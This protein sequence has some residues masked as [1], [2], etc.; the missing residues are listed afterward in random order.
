VDFDILRE[1]FELVNIDNWVLWKYITHKEGKP[2]KAPY[3]PMRPNWG[4]K[5][6][7]PRTW[8][9]FELAYKQ[10]HNPNISMEGIGFEVYPPTNFIK[11]KVWDPTERRKV[12]KIVEL[13][14]AQKAHFTKH[15]TNRDG[16]YLMMVDVDHCVEKG[17]LNAKA[18]HILSTLNSYSEYSPSGT[19]IHIF[20]WADPPEGRRCR[21]DIEIYWKVRF[22]TITGKTVE[23]CNKPIAVNVEGFNQIYAEHVGIYE[24]KYTEVANNFDGSIERT[25]IESDQQL[26]THLYYHPNDEFRERFQRLWSGDFTDYRVPDKFENAGERDH[27]GADMA[28]INILYWW[29]GGDR[30]RTDTLFRSSGL[31]RSK[32]EDRPDYREFTLDSAEEWYLEHN[33]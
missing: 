19:G 4:A 27:S 22:L 3:I 8:S 32:W 23:G 21:G 17:K 12:K 15:N 11:D 7:D 2:T 24:R 5:A 13:T 9:T 6:G 18:E 28:L 20:L 26:K 1:N 30:E 29:T 33:K 25:I 10:Y 31:C 16:H 14:P